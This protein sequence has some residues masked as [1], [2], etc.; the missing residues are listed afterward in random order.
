[1][2]RIGVLL[3]LAVCA[4]AAAADDTPNIIL[5]D[6]GT[7]VFAVKLPYGTKDPAA[8]SEEKDGA[9]HTKF[10]ELYDWLAGPQ[11]VDS[12]LTYGTFDQFKSAVA[13]KWGEHGSKAVRQVIVLISAHGDNDGISAW[14]GSSSV[15][16]DEL[17]KFLEGT[18]ARMDESNKHAHLVVISDPCHSGQL[19]RKMSASGKLHT[20]AFLSGANADQVATTDFVPQLRAV[21]RATAAAEHPESS[22]WKATWRVAYEALKGRYDGWGN[23]K[24][25]GPFW[26]SAF[27]ADSAMSRPLW[28]QP[29]LKSKP[30]PTAHVHTAVVACADSGCAGGVCS[31]Q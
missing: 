14:D 20:W 17:E 5:N 23:D 22:R 27:Y 31:A 10:R 9:G 19:W 8:K 7:M 4:S 13:Q 26:V 11:A 29:D 28:T 1:M 12:S 6:P 2:K 18:R 24:K 25:S 15:S 16:W 30:G 21:L 3:A